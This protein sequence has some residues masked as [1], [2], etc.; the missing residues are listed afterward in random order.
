MV[1]VC[2]CIGLKS[3]QHT[4]RSLAVRSL[5][6]SAL[7]F[8]IRP[9]SSLIS[10]NLDI[11]WI[12]AAAMRRY[13]RVLLFLRW[14]VCQYP[15]GEYPTGY[16]TCACRLHSSDGRVIVQICPRSRLGQCHL[17]LSSAQRVQIRSSQ[18]LNISC[19]LVFRS[20]C[21]DYPH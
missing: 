2:A 5:D 12:A 15:S 7:P 8:A 20:G 16:F 6:A 17:K 9:K 10:G 21:I 19:G 3:A 11:V 13:C 4:C 18:S 1:D 14:Q